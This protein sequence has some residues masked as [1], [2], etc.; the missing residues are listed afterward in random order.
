LKREQDDLT[1][2]SS[3]RR[4]TFFAGGNL[5][6]LVRLRPRD[7]PRF[8]AHLDGI[9][10]QLRTLETLGVP[11]VAAINGAAMGGGLELALGTHHRVLA[12]V[13]GAQVGLP[14]ESRTSP[15]SRRHRPGRADA[16]R[17]YRPGEGAAI[18][19]AVLAR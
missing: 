18:G 14:G 11:V 13:R 1:G 19:C 10:A 3:P 16:R 7:A 5:N 15:D 8:T 9:K 4:K 6:E 12:D 17:G 2:S